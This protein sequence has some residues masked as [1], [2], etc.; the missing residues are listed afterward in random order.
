V[1]ADAGS[2][3][4]GPNSLRHRFRGRAARRQSAGNPK[5]VLPRETDDES[6]DFAIDQWTARP[7]VWV[8]PA[9]RHQPGKPTLPRHSLS[10]LP[11]RVTEFSTP[12]VLT[13]NDPAWTG[14]VGRVFPQCSLGVPTGRKPWLS[15][16]VVRAGSLRRSPRRTRCDPGRRSRLRPGP[17][18]AA[19]RGDVTSSSSGRTKGDRFLHARTRSLPSSARTGIRFWRW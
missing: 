6:L 5:P 1:A 7:T 19:P 17:C 3:S 16:T 18:F 4:N 2:G 15:R 8:C 13:P 14:V 11:I 10:D 12:R 9:A